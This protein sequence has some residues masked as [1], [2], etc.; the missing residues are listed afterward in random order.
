M[1][2]KRLRCASSI[3]VTDAKAPVRRA[4]RARSIARLAEDEGRS[5]V[6]ADSF[7]SR[8]PVRVVAVSARS[9]RNHASNARVRVAVEKPTRIKLK[10]PAGITDGSRLRS[11][12]NGEAGIRGGPKGDLY[13][14]I[15]IKEHPIFQR[16]EDNLFCEVPIPFSL[17]ALGGEV[18]SPDA[19]RKSECQNTGGNAKRS[20]VQIARQ[21]SR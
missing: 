2:I 19:R 21:R 6:R 9:L 8:R 18:A 10:I 7:R 16:D 11:T 20:D 17:A 5:S 13:V 1:W 12:Q 14:V 15:H 4:D 3:P